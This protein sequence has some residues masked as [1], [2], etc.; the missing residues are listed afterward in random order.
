MLPYST[1][2]LCV[3]AFA[4]RIKSYDFVA[5]VR[6]EK[7]EVTVRYNSDSNF[8]EVLIKEAVSAGLTIKNI[9]TEE[10]SLEDIFLILTG[11][12]LRDSV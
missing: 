4:A 1:S 7:N 8:I 2:F 9:K 5:S 6:L 11:K 12:E 3:E 10:P